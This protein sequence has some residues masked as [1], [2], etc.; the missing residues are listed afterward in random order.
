LD[1]K[2]DAK[3]NPDFDA[4]PNPDANPYAE[5]NKGDP[6]MAKTSRLLLMGLMVLAVG[7]TPP[8]KWKIVSKMDLQTPGGEPEITEI[9]DL[10]SVPLIMNKPLRHLPGDGKAVVGELLVIRGTNLGRQPTVAFGPQPMRVLA[11]T[12]DGG[13]VV[14]APAASAPGKLRVSV[15]HDRGSASK[16]ME[17]KRYGLAVIPGLPGIQVLDVGTDKVEPVGKPLLATAPRFI[18]LH[19]DGSVAYATTSA[20]QPRL[21]VID[22]AAAGKPKIVNQRK[23]GMWKVIGLSVAAEAKVAAVVHEK[24][25]LM[26]DLDNPRDPLRYNP[27]RFP[28]GLLKSGVIDIELSP[29]GKTLAVLAAKDNTLVLFDVSDPND[30]RNTDPIRLLPDAKEPLV[31]S[32]RFGY[33]PRSP[34]KQVL[35][36]ATGDTPRSQ[37][38]GKHPPRQLKYG[39]ISAVDKTVL[40]KLKPLGDLTLPSKLTPLEVASSYAVSQVASASVIRREPSRMTFFA[41]MMHPDLFL[42]GK[43]RL[44]TPTGLQQ[45]AELLR[46]LEN[47]G[48]ILRTDH[49]GQGGA[50]Y[51]GG[52]LISS[53]ALTGDGRQLLGVTCRPDVTVD[54]P[55]VE[56]PCGLL[57]KPTGKGPA[58]YQA[59]GKLPISRFAPPFRF[60]VIALQP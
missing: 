16:M 59:M 24:A 8:N 51:E 1:A 3:P 49:R 12:E 60:G 22:L 55:K 23:L 14:R 10:G 2:L 41:A 38:V 6:L 9:Q 48:A 47:W 20:K 17:L 42:L 39:V 15:T 35:W 33:E 32:L 58:R 11:R 45:G 57:V 36:V 56:I 13:I 25:I 52:D 43:Q 37:L 7:C 21:L 4:N 5:P 46:K 26:F 31:R 54:P 28:P 30:V 29:D 18:A 34:V 19:R 53:L 27:A 50:F 40:P 44:D